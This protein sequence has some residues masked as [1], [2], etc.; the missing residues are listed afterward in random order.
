MVRAQGP[1]LPCAGFVTLGN[2]SLATLGALDVF[3]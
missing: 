2:L 3:G 1:D